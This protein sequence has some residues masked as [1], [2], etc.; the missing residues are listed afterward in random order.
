[1]LPF[2]RATG[3]QTA[4]RKD[5][6]PFFCLAP[7]ASDRAN[8][9]SYVTGYVAGYFAGYFSGPSHVLYAGLNRRSESIEGRIAR[10]CWYGRFYAY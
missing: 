3:R 7:L 9:P 5:D 4:R 8:L 6:G 2:D 1:M 10:R